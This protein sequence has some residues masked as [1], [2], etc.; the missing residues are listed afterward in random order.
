[1]SPNIQAKR[2]ILLC[3]NVVPIYIK[4]MVANNT[5]NVLKKNQLFIAFF[6]IL[7][8]IIYDQFVHFLHQ[9]NYH[10]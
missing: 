5:E 2:W 9:T 3:A 1:M 7:L 6:Y 10:K 4:Q 8:Q